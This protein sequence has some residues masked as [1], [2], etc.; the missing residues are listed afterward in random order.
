MHERDAAEDE[1]HEGAADVHVAGRV[2]PSPGEAREERVGTPDAEAYQGQPAGLA[3]DGSRHD[4]GQGASGD[5]DSAR[6]SGVVF[7]PG[8]RLALQGDE[9][10]QQREAQNNDYSNSGVVHDADK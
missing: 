10:Q 2:R 3:P 7:Q 8:R 4:R 6:Q 1:L 9:K 5:K